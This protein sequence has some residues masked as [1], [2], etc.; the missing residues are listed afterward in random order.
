MS[1][2][3][4]LR[5]IGKATETST[6]VAKI[7]AELDVSERQAYRLLKKAWD[8]KEIRKSS[9]PDRSC[10]NFLPEW[11]H[12]LG[13][14]ETLDFREAF[15]YRCFRQLEEI[16][17]Q[18]IYGPIDMW[19]EPRKALQELLFFIARLPKEVK[20]KVEPLKRK[21]LEQVAER[22][23]KFIDE[24]KKTSH[25]T[26]KRNALLEEYESECLRAVRILVD[27]VSTLL[28]EYQG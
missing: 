13:L 10:L 24:D 5:K 20:A 22:Q 14:K 26:E 23:Q 16:S 25:S 21:Q 4:I 3:D 11:A 7:E 15:L 1:V 12:L 18:A 6:L 2:A 9:L 27:R 8:E 17:H 19:G 28:H